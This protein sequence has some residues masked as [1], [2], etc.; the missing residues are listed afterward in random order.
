M[1][2]LFCSTYS[3][4]NLLRLSFIQKSLKAQTKSIKLITQ[5]IIHI[6]ETDISCDKIIFII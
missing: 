2:Y 1:S 6:S 4:I 5:Y 3:G